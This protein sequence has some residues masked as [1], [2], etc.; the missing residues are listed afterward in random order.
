MAAIGRRRGA[1][2]WFVEPYLQVKLGLMFLVV[3]FLFAG[4][5]GFIFWFYL[6][7]VYNAVSVYFNLTGGQSNEILQKMSQP[8]FIGS[9]LIFAFIVTT[10]LVS[11][12]YTH[13]IYGPLVSIHRYLDDIINYRPSKPLLLRE[14]DQL[15]DLAAKLNQVAQLHVDDQRLVALKAIHRWLDEELSGESKGP[16][17]LRDGDAFVEMAEKLNRLAARSASENLKKAN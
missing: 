2:S 8:L 7:D 14:S 9:G 1:I 6:W 3:N 16:L 5:I 17:Q 10:I 15:K 11:A 4:M 13:R 12:R